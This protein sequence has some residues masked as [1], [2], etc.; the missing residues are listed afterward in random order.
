MSAKRE[1][2]KRL[3]IALQV[4]YRNMVTASGEDEIAKAAVDLGQC[5]ND[6][7]EAIIWFLRDY[8]GDK[9]Q[10]PLEKR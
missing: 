9:T 4:R 2:A 7:I 8:G 6:N 1:A 5:F 3:G 10:G